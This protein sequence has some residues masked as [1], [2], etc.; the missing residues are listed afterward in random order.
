MQA[1]SFAGGDVSLLTT[2]ILVSGVPRAGSW[3]TDR[4]IVGDLPEQVVAGGGLR[5]AT[6]TITWAEQP[7]V[8]DTAANPWNSS[9]GWMP[10]QGDTV[11]VRV[12]DGITTWVQFYGVIDETT[13]DVGGSLQSTIIDPTDWLSKPFT[14][15]TVLRR[16]PP[17]TEGGAYI[18]VGMTAAYAV[19]RLFRKAGYEGTPRQEPG[20]LMSAPLQTSTWPEWGNIIAGGSVT[21]PSVTHG[22]YY[23]AP[24][25][26]SMG[27]FTAIY[28]PHAV[29]S[30][31][32]PVQM[33]AMADTTHTGSFSMDASYG[34]NVLRLSINP[35]REAIALLNGVEL[36]R[37]AMGVNTI[38]TLLVKAGA[39]T[40]KTFTGALTSAVTMP[41]GT[42]LNSVSISGDANSRI[43][44]VQLSQPTL[45]S[46]F[47]SISHTP[48]S[49]QANSIFLGVMDVL[50][51]MVGT[52]VRAVLDEI[53]KALLS[54]YWFTETGGLVMHGSDS[55]ASRAPVQTVTTADDI[56]KLS[57]ASNRLGVRSEVAV[58]YRLPALNNS[59]Y[60]NVLLWQGSGETMES[61]QEKSMFAAEPADEDWAEVDLG[62]VG[63]ADGFTAFNAGRGT[64]VG[65]YL[66]DS[67]GDWSASTGYD[68]WQPIKT[69]DNETRLFS[70]T[71][72][73][74]PTG[75]K[76]VL[77]T[78]D[79]ATNY[80][81]RMRGIGLPVLR[82]RARVKWQDTSLTSTTRGPAG[83]PAL[84]HDIRH[85]SVRADDTERPT[86]IADYIAEQVSVP[87]PVITGLEVAYDPRRQLGDV[88]KIKSEK[89]MGVELTALIVGVHN[90]AGDT[91]TQSLDV[92]IITAVTTF[93]T[94]GEWNKASGGSVSYEQWQALGPLPQTY[95]QF[96]TDPE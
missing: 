47:Q 37:L 23:Q 67:A 70:V 14:H 10:A 3:S 18:G 83:F 80:F 55:L 28:E 92:R 13:G 91:Y 75:K 73:T 41:A 79:D 9:A 22:L 95:Q 62:A 69:I 88:I 21:G 86:R 38:V 51:S 42:T 2:T 81:P 4:E 7:D 52:T 78:P 54:P 82:G 53:S 30:S 60:S 34:A 26:F 20:C 5:Q 61:G 89:L 24:W 11:S 72:G 44:G 45:A 19:D 96:N 58:K 6:G 29:I 27:D 76:L 93:T 46:E 31:A 1:G 15:S 49:Y 87:R 57:W 74:L 17:K 63:I 39:W 43:A 48:R 35:S 36:G 71:A 16:H 68:T 32:D 56:F 50:P 59:R 8:T 84:E 33:T 77:G 94:Y 12:T 64:W 90:S 25:G 40:I 85:W 66:E 65:S